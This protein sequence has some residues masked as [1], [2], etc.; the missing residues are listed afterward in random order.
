ML[1]DAKERMRKTDTIPTIQRR[2]D[3]QIFQGF[4]TLKEY[5]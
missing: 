3:A 5:Y 2:V 4:S 1:L